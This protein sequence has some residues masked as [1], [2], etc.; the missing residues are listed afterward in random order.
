ML[1]APPR[2]LPAVGDI[3]GPVVARRLVA[4]LVVAVL[5]AAA[6]VAVTGG[7]SARDKLAEWVNPSGDCASVEN[8]SPPPATIHNVPVGLFHASTEYALIVCNMLGPNTVYLRFKDR[9]TMLRALGKFP[10]VGRDHPCVLQAAIFTTD[11]LETRMA[12]TFCT[13]LHGTVT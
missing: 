4:L 5:A 7:D 2:T 6:V 3:A 9:A 13:R 12:R 11:G 8:D 1:G 10:A